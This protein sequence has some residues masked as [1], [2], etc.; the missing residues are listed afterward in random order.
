MAIPKKVLHTKKSP[1][2]R[3][4]ADQWTEAQ[5]KK[6]NAKQRDNIRR[7]RARLEEKKRQHVPARPPVRARIAKKSGAPKKTHYSPKIPCTVVKSIMDEYMGMHTNSAMSN[8][9]AKRMQPA[10]EYLMRRILQ[11][12][13]IIALHKDASVITGPIMI[14]A[15]QKLR[16]LKGLD[17]KIPIYARL[18]RAAKRMWESERGHVKLRFDKNAWTFVAWA[19]GSFLAGVG[20]AIDKM[21]LKRKSASISRFGTP[22]Y[23]RRAIVRFRIETRMPVELSENLIKVGEMRAR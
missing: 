13:R 16:I 6:M 20:R 19:G 21:M 4:S 3:K 17:Q 7:A 18:K 23:V 1:S 2:K 14:K 10:V 15:A 8:K 5:L 22:S 12:A 11:E 9:G